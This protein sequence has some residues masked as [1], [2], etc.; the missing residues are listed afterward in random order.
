MKIEIGNC[1]KCPF[2]VTEYNSECVGFDTVERCNL[3]SYLN[4]SYNP[5][6][7]YDMGD[8]GYDDQGCD[9]CNLEYWVEYEKN[10]ELNL[11]EPIFDKTKCE[12]EKLHQEYLANLPTANPFPDWCPLIELKEIIIKK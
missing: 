4:L 10:K 3:A 1:S 12:C 2:N 7:V 5:I 8:D 9:Y 6:A 11:P